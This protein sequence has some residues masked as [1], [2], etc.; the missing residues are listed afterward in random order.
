MATA[1]WNGH[2]WECDWL[3]AE[4]YSVICLD[5]A[6]DDDGDQTDWPSDAEVSALAGRRL[7]WFGAGDSDRGVEGIFKVVA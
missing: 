2:R 6:M 7:R 4:A 3:G 1:E 5:P